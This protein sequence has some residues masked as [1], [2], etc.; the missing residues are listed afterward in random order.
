MFEADLGGP[1]DG[2]LCFN[3]VHHLSPDGTRTLFAR[4][5]AALRPGAPLCVLDLFTRPAGKRPDS[6]AYM[7][8]FFHLTSGADTYAA[9]E[10]SEWLASSGFGAARLKKLP[11][12]PGLGL[13]RAE[14]L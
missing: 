11:Q 4:I 5:A 10:V 7:G 9:G 2:A 14:R 12:I 3:I 13:L 1:H 6:G 8:L